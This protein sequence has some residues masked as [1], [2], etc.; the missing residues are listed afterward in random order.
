[1]R[2]PQEDGGPGCM[3]AMIVAIACAVVAVVTLMLL[4]IG[5][6]C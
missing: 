3:I 6:C 2:E 1:M 4:A 5:Q